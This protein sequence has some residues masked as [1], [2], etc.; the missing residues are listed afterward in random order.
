MFT[1][2][3]ADPWWTGETAGWI[4][5]I[6]GTAMGL[7]GGV[8]GCMGVLVHRGKAKRFVLGLMCSVI[9]VCLGILALGIVALTL[10]Q[11]YAVWYPCL[12]MGF[13]GSCIPGFLLPVFLARYRQAEQRLLEA[14][15][16]RGP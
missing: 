6:G 14:G 16:L 4:G 5:A 15:A 2:A 3:L 13:L 12:L 7:V 11:P 10:G 9:I 1:L 8:L